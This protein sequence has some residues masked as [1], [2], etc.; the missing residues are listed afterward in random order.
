MVPRL[1]AE[2]VMSCVDLELL[3]PAR[4]VHAD[5]VP[6]AELLDPLKPLQIQV[7]VCVAVCRVSAERTLQGRPSTLRFVS[8]VDVAGTQS[9]VGVGWRG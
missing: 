4:F 6:I 9:E 5:P 7:C 8:V 1:T 3:L 2:R